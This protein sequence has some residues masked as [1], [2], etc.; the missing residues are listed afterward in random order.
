MDEVWVGIRPRRRQRVI[1]AA[2]EAKSGDCDRLLKPNYDDKPVD[3][4]LSASRTL[5]LLYATLVIVRI[6][7]VLGPCIGTSASS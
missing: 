1:A 7:I 3:Q 5:D 2:T 6:L 4:L